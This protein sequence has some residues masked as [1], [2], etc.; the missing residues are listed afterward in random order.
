LHTLTAERFP[1]DAKAGH[2]LVAW[3]QGCKPLNLGGLGIHNPKI[4]ER[5]IENEMEVD[6]ERERDFL[7]RR[8]WHGLYFCLSSEAESMLQAE[9]EVGKG[10]SWLTVIKPTF[11]WGF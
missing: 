3:Q 2:S 9:C 10:R 8:A 6:R 11:F 7:E 1:Q 5:R 4:P